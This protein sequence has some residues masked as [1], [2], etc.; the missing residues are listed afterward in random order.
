MDVQTSQETPQARIEWHLACIEARRNGAPLPKAPWE[1]IEEKK[2]PT[3]RRSQEG[4]SRVSPLAELTLPKRPHVGKSHPEPEGLRRVVNAPERSARGGAEAKSSTTVRKDQAAP[5]FPSRAT[6][7]Q[8]VLAP[9]HKVAV[10]R[11]QPMA[12]PV[13]AVASK[14]QQ[15]SPVQ[16]IS[17][18]RD[19]EVIIDALLLE[20]GIPM[21]SLTTEGRTRMVFSQYVFLRQVVAPSAKLGA[22]YDIGKQFQLSGGVTEALRIADAIIR[23]VEAPSREALSVAQAEAQNLLVR[24]IRPTNITFLKHRV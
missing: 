18:R 8:S 11:P 17:L 14:P 10:P 21:A 2:E 7:R 9:P 5:R 19:K 4:R 23:V 22:Q 12:E 6:L 3:P 20:A 15:S 24:T 1:S 13:R 16:E